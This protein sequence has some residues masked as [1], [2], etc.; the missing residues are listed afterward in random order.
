MKDNP[1]AHRALITDMR[2]VFVEM[3]QCENRKLCTFC[4]IQV[5]GNIITKSKTHICYQCSM[6]VYTHFSGGKSQYILIFPG[7]KISMGEK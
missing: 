6:S 3:V 7:R 1:E 5:N 2:L 4:A